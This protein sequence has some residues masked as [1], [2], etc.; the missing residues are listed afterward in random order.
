MAAPKYLSPKGTEVFEHGLA[1]TYFT[2]PLPIISGKAQGIP[3]WIL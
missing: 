3:K 1:Y 2:L